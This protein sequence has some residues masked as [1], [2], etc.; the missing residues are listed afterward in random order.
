MTESTIQWRELSSLEAL[1]APQGGHLATSEGLV[2]SAN[3]PAELLN[4]LA[5]L[6]V[7][8]LSCPLAIEASELEASQLEVLNKLSRLQ[9]TVIAPRLSLPGVA[10][11]AARVE[12]NLSGEAERSV[13]LIALALYELLSEMPQSPPEVATWSTHADGA[14][15]LSVGGEGWSIRITA[16]RAATSEAQH[17]L[18][19]M[20]LSATALRASQAIQLASPL[21]PAQPQALITPWTD[22]GRARWRVALGLLSRA[23]RYGRASLPPEA[24]IDERAQLHP[25]V[26]LSGA[27]KIGPRAKVWHFSKLLGPLTIGEDCNLGQNVVVERHASLGRNVKVQNNVSIYSGVVLEDD[28]FCGPSMVFT[29][30]GTPRSHYPRRGSYEETRVKR[31]A[32]IG[33]NATVVCGATIGRYAL[34]GAGAVVTKDVPDYALAFGN[35]ARVQ[36]WV[37]YCG[38]GL[39]LGRGEE[40]SAGRAEAS[41]E[42]CG[43]SYVREGLSVTEA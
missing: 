10:L 23:R 18:G 35:P 12:L 11:R 24:E 19:D 38:E 28:V 8:E 22:E 43:R 40:A 16:Q 32:S 39:S 14:L 42:E 6:T 34:I 17:A 33:A 13:G 27:V 3:A 31:G 21:L 30:V 26:E 4:A 29:N 15:D 25:S 1:S 2:L 20:S 37:C 7:E 9:L 36:G 5:S 41:C